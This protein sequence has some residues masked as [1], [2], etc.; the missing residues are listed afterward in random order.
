MTITGLVDR[1]AE[2][3]ES[4]RPPMRTASDLARIVFNHKPAAKG[5]KEKTSVPV[6]F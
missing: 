3:Q 1:I 6:P 5:A 2:V 4:R